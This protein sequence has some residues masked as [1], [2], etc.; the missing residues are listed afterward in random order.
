MIAQS[1]VASGQYD[2]EEVARAIL[3]GSPNIRTRK[4]GHLEDYAYRT[5]TKAWI[6]PTVQAH[7]DK[8]LARQQDRGYE[9]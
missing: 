4:P 7:R 9:H 3:G 2:A 6:D 1:M 8:N 5:A